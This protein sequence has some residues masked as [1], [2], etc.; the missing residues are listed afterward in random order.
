MKFVKVIKLPAV[1]DISGGSRSSIY[2]WMAEDKFPRSIS[3]GGKA[4]GW[5]ES[6]IFDWINQRID[7]RDQQIEAKKNRADC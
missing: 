5:I 2:K 6:E 1:M 3:L 7:E 4:V